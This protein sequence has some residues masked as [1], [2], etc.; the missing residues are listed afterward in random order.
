MQDCESPMVLHPAIELSLSE[1]LGFPGRDTGPNS[2]IIMIGVLRVG[3]LREMCQCYRI[4]E[5]FRLKGTIQFQPLSYW[6]GPVFGGHFPS[7]PVAHLQELFLG[8]F[9]Q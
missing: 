1:T 4:T 3:E 7:V 5:W 6:Q 9:L 2:K 8:A